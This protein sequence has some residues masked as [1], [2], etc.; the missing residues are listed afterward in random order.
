MVTSSSFWSASS[1]R[2]VTVT[3]CATFQVVAVKVAE[4]TEILLVAARGMFGVTVTWP[5]GSE[6]RRTVYVAVP[7]SLTSTL[8]GGSGLTTTPLMSSSW[9]VRVTTPL[10]PML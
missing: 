4:L 6:S 5:V 9:M 8:A 10:A 3:V 7:P 1:S 2:A